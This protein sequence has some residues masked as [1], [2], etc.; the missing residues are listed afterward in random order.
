MSNAPASYAE[1]RSNPLTGCLPGLQCWDRCWARRF[2]Q[3]H[4]GRFGYCKTNPFQPTVHEDRMGEWKRWRRP[5]TIALCFMGDAFA[6]AGDGHWDMALGRMLG[7]VSEAPQ[8][9][10]L[11][12]TKRIGRAREW[13][14]RTS[15][16][17]SGDR[18]Q[19]PVL[20][21]PSNLWIGVSVED[22]D[23]LARVD[24]LRE[25]PA[26]HRWI[27]I[28]P[29]VGDVGELDLRGISWLV[30]GC[31][32]GPGRRPFDIAWA[33]SVRDQCAAA[34]TAY[35]LK[36]MPTPGCQRHDDD[37]PFAPCD[38]TCEERR[39]VVTKHPT[40]DGRTHTDLPW[41]KP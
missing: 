10:F 2:A 28:E 1:R 13:V 39:S 12:L 18:S 5:S 38:E 27:S 33:R 23:S 20:G 29:Q 15:F 26:A 31:E 9:R 16:Y 36:Q 6:M 4:A 25:T 24:V 22:R 17:P 14:S 40:L 3:R 35:Y 30:Q 21:F 34:G 41:V 37:C 8:H 32:S 19:R 11:L 7:H